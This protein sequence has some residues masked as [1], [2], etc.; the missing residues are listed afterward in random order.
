M[1]VYACFYTV[2]GHNIYLCDGEGE[3]YIL[4]F[5]SIGEIGCAVAYVEHYRKIFCED[6]AK[7]FHMWKWRMDLMLISTGYTGHWG[8]TA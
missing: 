8:Q 4:N 3:C 2:R 7:G 1:F 5:Y 6:E